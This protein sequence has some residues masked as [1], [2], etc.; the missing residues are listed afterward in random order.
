MLFI[1]K[2]VV[3][4]SYKT[5][6]YSANAFQHC[7]SDEFDIIITDEKEA[8]SIFYND[9]EHTSNYY[10]YYDWNDYDD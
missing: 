2:R 10:Y 6:D 1:L 7:Y 5:V 8:P 9:D 3:Y 4:I